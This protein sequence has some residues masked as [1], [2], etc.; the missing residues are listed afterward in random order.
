M[1]R[2]RVKNTTVNSKTRT[3]DKDLCLK[4]QRT[5]THRSKI[6]ADAFEREVTTDLDEETPDKPKG[7]AAAHAHSDWPGGRRDCRRH[8][9]LAFGGDHP[10][11]YGS[12]TILPHQWANCSCVCC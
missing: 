3:Q 12:L 6:D 11:L 5:T 8:G 4:K 7:L 2:A 1:F 10:V 9:Q